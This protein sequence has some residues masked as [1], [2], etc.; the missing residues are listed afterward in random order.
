VVEVVEELNLL[1]IQAQAVKLVEQVVQVLWLR[2]HRQQ[3]EFYL[4]HVVHAHQ[5]H[6][7]M[8][9]IK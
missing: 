4:Q 1:L 3:Q 7:L 2:E 6:Q 5:L 9:K 8:D